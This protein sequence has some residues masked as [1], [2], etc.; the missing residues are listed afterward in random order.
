MPVPR[1]YKHTKLGA[2]SSCAS[3]SFRRIKAGHALLTICCPRGYWNK[4][5]KRCRVGTRAI[6]IDKPKRR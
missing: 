3:G 2:R 5:T 1:G 4:R 6:G